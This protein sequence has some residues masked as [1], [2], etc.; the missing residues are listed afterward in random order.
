MFPLELVMRMSSTNTISGG[1]GPAGPPASAFHTSPHSSSW[2]L[3]EGDTTRVQ[4]HCCGNRSSHE[5]EM[6]PQ[7]M[8]LV[9]GANE[10]WTHVCPTPKT[11]SATALPP[12]VES[13]NHTSHLKTP[14]STIGANNGT[15][16]LQSVKMSPL[17]LSAVLHSRLSVIDIW[18][19]PLLFRTS[20]CLH[21][22]GNFSFLGRKVACKN[23]SHVSKEWRK[24][25]SL[26]GEELVITVASIITAN[27]WSFSEKLGSKLRP[28]A[29]REDLSRE[30]QPEDGRLWQGVWG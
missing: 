13:V 7:E 20:A 16:S 30:Q 2:R 18:F 11:S 6:C 29:Q 24:R 26:Q 21:Q 14:A 23:Q 27:T 17:I 22:K 25:V 19:L 9:K 12:S 1:P 8:Q 4:L 28:Y 5:V 3:S 15:I 10:T